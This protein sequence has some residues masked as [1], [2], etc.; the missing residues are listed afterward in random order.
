MA[1]NNSRTRAFETTA[2]HKK[3]HKKH[4]SKKRIRQQIVISILAVI[5]L[6]LVVFAT[7][8]IGKIL[9]HKKNKTPDIP[10][11]SIFTVNRNEANVHIGN[12]LLINEQ[13]KFDYASNG[14]VATDY[15][16]LPEG[17]VNLWSFKN[18]STNNSETKINISGTEIYAPTYE[19]ANPNLANQICLDKATLNAFNKM[20]IDYCKTLDLSSYSEGSASK[21]NIAWGWSHESDLL[22]NDIPKY[23]NAFFSQADGKSLTL[24]KVKA[25]QEQDRITESILIND[26]NWIY[27]NAHKYGFINRYPN[28]CEG[29]TGFNSNV[30]I[31]LRYIGI[32]HATYIYENGCC[33][34]KYLEDLRDN[35]SYENPLEFTAN[36]K[37]YKV[38]YVAYTGNPTS[39]PVPEDKTYS[40]SGNNMNGFIVTVEQ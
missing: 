25:G 16:T 10:P 32:E 19:L 11:A 38:Y 13:Y 4:K 29:H 9:T 20:M 21:I 2:G 35:Y 39:I 5:A 37:T 33:L 23:G 17:I 40:I 28:A 12:L 15:I 27:E 34:D 24:M 7:L 14:L 18:S 1:Q 26:F 8:I 31:H 30:R 36:G 6:I 3:N 22:T